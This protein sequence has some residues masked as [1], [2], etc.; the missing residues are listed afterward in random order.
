MRRA[1][2]ASRDNRVARQSRRETI[3]ERDQTT[4]PLSIVV[5][6]GFAY[7]L[8]AVLSVVALPELVDPTLRVDE[9]L[10]ARVER[11]RIAGDFE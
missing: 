8:L 11:M 1:T 6:S 3:E 5:L 2:I 7:Q 10:R 9:A 4:K